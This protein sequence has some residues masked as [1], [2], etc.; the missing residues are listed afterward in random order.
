MPQVLFVFQFWLSVVKIKERCD[1]VRI[2]TLENFSF[3]LRNSL[4][5]SGIGVSGRFRY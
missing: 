3:L 5:A 4:Y 2:G 1:G